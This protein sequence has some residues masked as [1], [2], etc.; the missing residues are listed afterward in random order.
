MILFVVVVCII[1]FVVVCSRTH[2]DTQKS[3]SFGM[4]MGELGRYAKPLNACLKQ[5][6]QSDPTE[7]LS[8]NNFD[9]GEYCHSIVSDMAQKGISPDE[10]PLED[11]FDVCR[12]KCYSGGYSENDQRK[13]V[14][15]CYGRRQIVRYCATTQCP[16][17]TLPHSTCMKQCVWTNLANNN[18]NTWVWTE[19]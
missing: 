1:L 15:E 5:C 17:S 4:V 8:Q 10:Y 18:Q 3:E 11:D 19:R 2:S 6:T 7:R 13:C 16:Y 12:K 9:C 14:G